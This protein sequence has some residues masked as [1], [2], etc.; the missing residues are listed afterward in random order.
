MKR[1]VKMARKKLPAAEKAARAHA[2]RR[3]HIDRRYRKTMRA[4]TKEKNQCQRDCRA[5]TLKGT[6]A[7]RDCDDA[8]RA[9]IN[10]RR[11]IRTRQYQKSLT[12]G[13]KL[14]GALP[15]AHKAK[16]KTSLARS[17][18]RKRRDPD[19]MKRYKNWQV[20]QSEE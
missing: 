9:R 15:D 16:I 1:V 13:R 14:R 11:D 19:I 10:R 17:W 12:T 4:Y 20:K 7:R 2:R 3:H 8:Y 5:W 6:P 18:R